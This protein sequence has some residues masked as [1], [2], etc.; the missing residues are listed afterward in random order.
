VLRE[1]LA[2]VERTTYAVP[3]GLGRNHR[4]VEDLC[5]E[6]NEAIPSD[7]MVIEEDV[8]GNLTFELTI[9]HT[10]HQEG[11]EERNT[12]E[13]SE[14]PLGALG[15]KWVEK[16]VQEK[17]KT[18]CRSSYK[19][20]LTASAEDFGFLYSQLLENDY[21]CELPGGLSVVAM[22]PAIPCDL[23]A[24]TLPLEYHQTGESETDVPSAV[25]RYINGVNYIVP[26]A[27]VEE[28]GITAGFFD[29]QWEVRESIFT[30]SRSEQEKIAGL[31][32]DGYYELQPEGDVATHIVLGRQRL[33]RSEEVDEE[34]DDSQHMF[35]QKTNIC[36]GSTDVTE[37]LSS[38]TIASPGRAGRP[39]TGD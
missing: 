38:F 18:S 14:S 29:T 32:A 16:F 35:R 23:F 27:N 7:V 37:N 21:C 9:V 13:V 25:L 8:P 15:Q 10:A 28:N 19:V 1:K 11:N 36:E 12:R 3:E 22:D 6:A 17:T 34:F 5:A 4:T 39:K 20:L 30:I 26:V 24:T 33:V 31:R 2:T